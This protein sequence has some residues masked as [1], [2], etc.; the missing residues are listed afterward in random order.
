VNAPDLALHRSRSLS[1]LRR[2]SVTIRRAAPRRCAPP[3]GAIC[4]LLLRY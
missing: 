3:L 2:E 4:E 1:V